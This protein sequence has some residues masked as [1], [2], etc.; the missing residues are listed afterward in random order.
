MSKY[1]SGAEGAGE[2]VDDLKFRVLGPEE[3]GCSRQKAVGNGFCGA[4]SGFWHS[5][6]G[7][8]NP[9]RFYSD[10]YPRNP[11][12]EARKSVLNQA[13]DYDH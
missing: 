4:G 10:P 3:Q 13:F 8:L 1:R 7:T 12:P 6:L 5:V 2:A 11:I 9:D